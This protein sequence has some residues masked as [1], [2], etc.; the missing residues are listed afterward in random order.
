MPSTAAC[1]TGGSSWGL[2]SG[3]AYSLLDV[4][5]V[6]NNGKKIMLAKV[7]NPWNT[8]K[9]TGPYNDKDKVWTTAL[10]N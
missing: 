4:K 9:Y 10:K 5:E 2:V 8:E 1:C 3:H 6:N 7:R